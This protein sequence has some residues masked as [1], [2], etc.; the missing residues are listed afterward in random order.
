MIDLKSY[1][2]EKNIKKKNQTDKIARLIFLTSAILSASFIV[3]I[4]LFTSFKGLSPFLQNYEGYHSTEGIIT[5]SPVNPI[6]FIF[7]NYW[8]GGTLGVSTDY[9][10][11]FA[12]INT[13]IVVFLA[14]ILAVPISVATALFVAKIAP[15]P[16][17]NFIRT[18]IELLASIPS[19]IYGVFGLGFITRFVIS[20]ASN[21]D[22][23]TA[24]GMS[25]MSTVIV[26]AMMILPTITAISETAIRAVNVDLI[27]GSLA[28]GASKM[29][30][31]FKVVL[32]AAKSGIFAGIVLGVGRAL[33]EATAVA[34]VSG[35]LFS[36]INFD[37]FGTTTTLTSRMLLGIKDTTGLDYDIRFSVGLILMMVIV[38]TNVGLKF[39]MRKLGGVDVKV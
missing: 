14:I 29:Q 39:I 34:M 1:I 12:I 9:G 26:L 38:I 19:I 30:T 18:V 7:G 6:N 20:I 4:I 11:G 2:T 8:L 17:A 36:G 37:L 10:I 5:L 25:L 35:N 13:L 28:L 32:T 24:A 33:G 27:N 15:K 16:V 22:V 31:F 21:Y 23:Q 3:L